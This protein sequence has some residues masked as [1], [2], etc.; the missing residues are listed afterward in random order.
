MLGFDICICRGGERGVRAMRLLCIAGVFLFVSIDGK[1]MN[2][3]L[4]LSC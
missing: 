3:L 1:S 4:A 2:R